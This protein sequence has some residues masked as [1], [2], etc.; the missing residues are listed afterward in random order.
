MPG[1]SS[2]IGGITR[3]LNSSTIIHSTTFKRGGYLN[4]GARCAIINIPNTN[5]LILWN[6]IPYSDELLSAIDKTQ[7]T[8]YEIFAIII[9]DIEHTLAAEGIKEK[10]PQV[11]VI[12]PSG[13]T[14]KPNL[15]IDYLF[16]DAAANKVING[17][18]VLEELADYK[19]L[20][21]N[22]HKNKELLFLDTLNSTLFEADLIFNIPGSSDTANE[23]YVNKNQN[24]GWSFLTRYLHPQSK[25]GGVLLRKLIPLN[26]ENRKGIQALY[27]LP[28]NSIVV[29]H[30]NVIENNGKDAVKRLFGSYL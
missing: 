23:Q 16:D 8:N 18:E 28:F 14:D 13:I 24:A 6:S 29:A 7:V 25:V 10:F 3:R 27:S 15:K 11:K 1:Y 12:G 21:L 4:F 26:E 5:K 19:F 9:P 2:P 22:G 17:E 20:Y 30:G